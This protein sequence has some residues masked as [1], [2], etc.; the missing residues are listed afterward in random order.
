MIKSVSQIKTPA[1]KI[2]ELFVE[3]KE[4]TENTEMKLDIEYC[5]D[6]I[7]SN[8]L[9]EPNFLFDDDADVG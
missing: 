9:Y 8:K 5:I 7:A 1:E 3:L 6:R 2:I 4:L